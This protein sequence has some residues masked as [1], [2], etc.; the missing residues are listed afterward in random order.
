MAENCCIEHAIGETRAVIL[1]K[2]KPVEFLLRRWSDQAIPNSGDIYSGR[3]K[4]IDNNLM[5]AFVDLGEG[6]KT[7]TSS[8]KH[9]LAVL[10]FSMMPH[11]KKL[12]EG[13]MVRIKILRAAEADKGP[14][15]EFIEESD[16]E[17]PSLE[18]KLSMEENVRMLY[19]DMHIDEGLVDGIEWAAQ[20]EVSV[21]GGGYIY[22]E[23][24]RAATMIDVDTAG[25][26]KQKISIESAKEI[27]HQIRLRGIGGLVLIDF[28][29]FRRKKER[30]DVWQTLK[31]SF[32]NDPAGLIK[33][34][35]FS[36][37]DTVELTRRRTGPTISQTIYNSHGELSAETEALL[38]LRRLQKEARIDGGAKWTLCL[39]KAAH[40]W[41]AAD[42][43]DWR[44]PL[45]AKIGARFTLECGEKTDVYKA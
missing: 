31:D 1:R 44:G 42:I 32:A 18:K 34:A 19:P 30:A 33:L 14:L 21:T 38:G 35:L 9:N 26:Q 6:K 2:N 36:R 22:I 13:Q 41:L 15:A 25:G 23:H 40:D 39:P 11:A 12:V 4:T 17:K 28:P 43:I 16:A 20:T 5:M 27:A 45:T 8:E 10:R 3:I 7:S 29:N 37:F 24:T